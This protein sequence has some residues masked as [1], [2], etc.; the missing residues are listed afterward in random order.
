M[1]EI[2]RVEDL[3]VTYQTKSKSIY[4]VRNAAFTINQGDSMGVVGE[5][6]SGKSTLAMA[7][8]RLHDEKYTDITGKAIFENDKDLISISQSEMDTLRWKDISVVFQRA[9]NSLSPVH[10]I[11]QQVEDIYRI[12]EPKASRE[13]IRERMVSLLKLVNLPKRVYDLYPHEMS[14]G[15]LQR[16]AIAISLLHNPKLIVFDEATTA[17][18]VVTQGQILKEIVEMEKTLNMTRIMI[19]HDMSVV[20]ESCNKIAVMY[21]GELL[22]TGM[23]KDIFKK[24]CH[25]YTQGLIKSFPALKGGHHGKLTSIPGN[26]PDL[27]VSCKGCIFADRCDRAEKKCFEEKP[28]YKAMQDGRNV[29]CHFAEEM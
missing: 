7:V 14:G 12:H 19:T 11:R 23:V 17:L 3:N 26:L 24:P 22:E 2:L 8:L 29:A 10:R 9:M 15:M 13:E 20:A 25:P 28:S 21:A 4:A 18:D 27:S 16:T 5:S 6:G 1:K